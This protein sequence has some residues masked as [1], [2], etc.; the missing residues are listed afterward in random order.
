MSAMTSKSKCS[1]IFSQSFVIINIL[2]S[3]LS[4]LFNYI[5]CNKKSL[6]LNKKY[7]RDSEMPH[8][9]SSFSDNSDQRANEKKLVM[10][11]RFGPYSL[12]REGSRRPNCFDSTNESIGCGSNYTKQK[13]IV[14]VYYDTL[15]GFWILREDEKGFQRETIISPFIMHYHCPLVEQ[16]GLLLQAISRTMPINFT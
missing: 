8:T 7:K 5:F 12:S 11:S 15:S 6:K 13:E 14:I 9:R 1:N 2:L 3:L 10:Y 16:W 4:P